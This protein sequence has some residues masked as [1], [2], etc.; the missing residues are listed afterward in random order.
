MKKTILFS[1]LL[2]SISLLSCKKYLEVKPYDY[3]LNDDNVISD[4]A[5]VETAVRGAYRSL[6]TLNYGNAF[7]RTV[8]QSGLDVRSINN[9]QTD[10]NTINFDLRSDI[11]FL[12][13]F[14]SNNY[15]TI[16]R[17]NLVIDKA[18]SVTDAN[19]TP[20]LRNQLIG[21]AYFI[22]ALSYFDLTRLFGGVQIFLKPTK[23]VEDKLGVPRS[24][25][26]AVYAQVLDDLNQ[27]EALLPTTVTRNRA[28]KYTVYALKARLYLYDNKFEEAE[29]EASKVLAVTASYKLNKPF[30][31]AT[32]TT[33]SILEL[34]F[35]VNNLNPAFNL[36]NGT[37]R[38]LEPKAVLHNLLNDSLVGGGRKILSR[39]TGNNIF[40]GIFASNVSPFYVLRTA[41]VV[42]IRAE[43]RA[44]KASPD[45]TGALSDLNSVRARSAIPNTT[46]TTQDEI[47]LAIENERRVEFALEPHRWFDLVRTDRALAVLNLNNP[48]K[49]IYPIPGSELRIDPSLTQNPGY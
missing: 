44:K 36:W 30:V 42:L 5:S 33:E 41:E 2:L 15:N 1:I 16:N 22:R 34:S 7:Q 19:L 37:N 26:T 25:K 14:W 17:A 28:T 10:L 18:P 24:S 3:V 39:K 8:L 20:A 38:T 12:S 35:D 4:K 40:G 32:G 45:L 11:A 31:L 49:Y 46:A 43:A 47:I 13:E 27:A 9:G 21:E 48:N 6:A 29:A 23:I